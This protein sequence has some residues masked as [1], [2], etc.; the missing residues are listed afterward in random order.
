MS[1]PY[2]GALVLVPAADVCL[3]LDVAGGAGT[4]KAA[5][6][7]GAGRVVAAVP[8]TVKQVVVLVTLVVVLTSWLVVAGVASQTSRTVLFLQATNY[9]VATNLNKSL[10]R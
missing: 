6:V 2:L 5:H 1:P 10:G 9:I 4:G 8:K 7:V 3:P